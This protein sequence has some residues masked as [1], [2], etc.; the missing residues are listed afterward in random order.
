MRIISGIL[1]PGELSELRTLLAMAAFDDGAATSGAIAG[2]S[3]KNLQARVAEPTQKAATLVQR[4]LLDHG[5]FVAATLPRRMHLAF[6]R[7]DVGMQ[8]GPHHDAALVGHGGDRA[9]R[10]DISMTL[11]LSAPADYDGGELMID[12]PFGESKV[13]LPAGSAVLYPGNLRHWVAPITRG[14][15]LAAFGWIHSLIRGDERRKLVGDLDRL[16]RKL[17]ELD[18]DRDVQQ[19]AATCY[20]NLMRHW[21]EP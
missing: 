17:V 5:E 1:T 9:V 6:N 11:F 3:K 19:L 14:S 21:A 10:T 18:V 15:R 4:A 20:Q 2:G 16:R 13:K 8:Y 12:S 7:Y